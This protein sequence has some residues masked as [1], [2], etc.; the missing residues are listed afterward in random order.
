VPVND[1][2][3]YN[4]D[5]EDVIYNQNLNDQY[6]EG[7]GKNTDLSNDNELIENDE[8]YVYNKNTDDFY[9]EKSTCLNSSCPV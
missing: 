5:D 6:E 9:Y 3:E 8:N 4:Y 2:N 7:C 1:V